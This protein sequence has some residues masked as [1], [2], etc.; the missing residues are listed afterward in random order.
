MFE[1]GD[2]DQDYNI[3]EYG[4]V[5]YVDYHIK[6]SSCSDIVFYF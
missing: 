4:G 2:D 1:N 5:V 3:G 6:E